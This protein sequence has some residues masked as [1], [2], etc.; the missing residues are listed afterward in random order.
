MASKLHSA[1]IVWKIERIGDLHC[2]FCPF[3]QKE[4]NAYQD[5]NKR[6]WFHRKTLLRKIHVGG[7]FL[8]TQLM[9]NAPT[10]A[11]IGQNLHKQKP[12]W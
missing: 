4:G 1:E 6:I 8:L 5:S 10:C 11:Y 9:Q 3:I 7:M 2:T 12:S